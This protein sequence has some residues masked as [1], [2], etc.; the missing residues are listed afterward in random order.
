MVSVRQLSV[1]WKA[2]LEFDKGQGDLAHGKL[3]SAKKH[4]EKAV[5]IAPQFSE[6]LNS[7]GTLAFQARDFQTAEQFFRKA[8]EK[9][10]DAF[11]PLVNLGGTLLALQRVDEAIEINRRAQEARPKDPLAA[12]QLG[13]SYYLAGNDEDALNYLLLTEQLDPNHYTNPQ[14]PLARLYLSHSDA[15]GAID[16]L[17]DFLKRH[18]DAPEAESVRKMLS[19]VRES[20]SARESPPV[21]ARP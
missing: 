11:E 16:E 3:D 13:M 14:L 9:D 4:F 1:P 21:S 2:Q 17:N 6:A 18:P 7:L 19:Q 12:A 5:Q 15:Q 20:S 10:A 8:L